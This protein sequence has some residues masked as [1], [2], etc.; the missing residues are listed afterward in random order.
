MKNR[1]SIKEDA[2]KGGIKMDIKCSRCKKHLE[3][4]DMSRGTLTFGGPLPTLYSGVICK[5][6]GRIECTDCK[7]GSI[8]DPC[9]WCKG[10][11]V[12]AYESEFFK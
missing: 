2:Y 12:P 6:C 5:S 8:S 11:V 7:T 10:N 4:L 1:V 3:K 9:S